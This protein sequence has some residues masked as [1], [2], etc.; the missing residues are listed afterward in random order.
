MKPVSRKTFLIAAMLAP[1]LT[2]APLAV[3]QTVTTFGLKLPSEVAGLRYSGAWPVT[4][5]DGRKAIVAGYDGGKKGEAVAMI[6]EE[7]SAP[8]AMDAALL[9]KERDDFVDRMDVKSNQALKPKVAGEATVKDPALANP[10]ATQLI[11]TEF[12]GEK[13]DQH[14]YVTAINGRLIGIRY[15]ASAGANTATDA[16]AFSL[17]LAKALKGM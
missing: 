8:Q 5:P 11:K 4:N 14:F 16:K 7:G 17:Q 9:K 10:F 13:T 12:A 1:L 2:A 3:A 15:K 6:F